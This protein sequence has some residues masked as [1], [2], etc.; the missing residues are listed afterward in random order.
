MSQLRHLTTPPHPYS[1]RYILNPRNTSTTVCS[2]GISTQFHC[3]LYSATRVY[4]PPQLIT[5]C[6]FQSTHLHDFYSSTHSSYREAAHFSFQ[7]LSITLIL[8]SSS[9]DTLSTTFLKTRSLSPLSH[10]LIF[11]STC[12]H[13]DPLNTA[14]NTLKVNVKA[15]NYMPRIYK[16]TFE[17]VY[18]VVI[19]IIVC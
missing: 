13:T 5:S 10:H 3:H 6:C 16:F 18:N 7:L 9:T 14:Q 2:P 4:K 11:Q 17:Q 19:Q 1:Q 15:T 8:T 12:H